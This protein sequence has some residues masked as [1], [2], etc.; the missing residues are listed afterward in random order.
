[1]HS[2]KYS[3]LLPVRNEAGRIDQ[4]VRAVFSDLGANPA[5][6]ICFAD[7]FSDDGT[8][9]RLRIL[10]DI[11]PFRL[12]RP[13]E[14][15]GR[16]AIRNLL[17]REARAPLLVFLDGDCKVLPGFFKAWEAPDLDPDIAYLGKISYDGHPRSGFSR[18]LARGS[19]IGKMRRKEGIPPAYFISQ[20]F[21]LSK[22]VFEKAG[23]FRTDLLGWGGEDV[24]LG[25]K[26]R[27]LGVPLRYN[28]DAE[29][30]HPSVTGLESYFA[31]LFHFGRVNLPV[32]I[33]DNPELSAQ[34]KLGF[35]RRPWGLIFANPLAFSLCRSLVTGAKGWPWPYA[36][37][38]YVIF[39][40]YARG[41]RQAP[42]R[43]ESP[44]P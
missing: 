23:G 10:A 39:N 20:N 11:F 19:G 14:N 43:R 31:R 1:M 22:A 34:F 12:I 9:E 4:V 28:G 33:G 32:L 27:R 8:H 2:P 5:W 30:R 41:Y 3:L 35:A 16:G 18:F 26:L 36:L 15:L 13:P 37:Y 17:A 21:R 38:R 25:C 42:P 40:C 24:D 44:A 6:E 29:V 7:D